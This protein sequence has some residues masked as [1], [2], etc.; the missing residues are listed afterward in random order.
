MEK[1]PD[2]ERLPM[3]M[4]RILVTW[5]EEDNTD[6]PILKTGKEFKNTGNKFTFVQMSRED[7]KR[8]TEMSSCAG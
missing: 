2:F 5:Q 3:S 4:G 7:I 8:L 1:F 6:F